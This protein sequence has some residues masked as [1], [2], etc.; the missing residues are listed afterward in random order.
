MRILLTN[1]DG[2]YA[3][4]LAAFYRALATDHEVCVVAPQTVQSAGAH[5]ITIRHPLVCQPLRVRREFDAV[6]VE[7]TPADCVKLALNVLLTPKPD[8]VVSGINA[9]QNTGIHVI[10]SGTVAAAIEA[11]IM[12]LPAVAVSLQ[13]SEQMD[14]ERSAGIARQIIDHLER[15]GQLLP[16]RVFNLNIPELGPG[17]PRGLRIAPQSTRAM[18]EAMEKRTDPN[19]REY[20]WLNGDFANLADDDTTDRSALRD[21]YA[22]LTPLQFDLTDRATLEQMRD[23]TWPTIAP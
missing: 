8:L 17:R 14:F 12:G 18:S 4:G 21:G 2:V 19:G 15:R 22:C 1:D 13:F 23:W 7:G 6:A 16:G 9:G 20:Y 10:Y 5:S 11:G 3:P